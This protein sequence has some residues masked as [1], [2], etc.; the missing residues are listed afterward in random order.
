MIVMLV[1]AASLQPPA[2][3][4][5]VALCR[6]ALERKAEG[7]VDNVTVAS[8]KTSRSGTVLIGRLTIFAGMGSAP[9]GSANTHHL[10]RAEYIFKCLVR[11]GRVRKTTLTQP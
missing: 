8:R 4:S 6:T 1:A 5:A 2:R 9:P 7:E 11:R 3:D 10:I